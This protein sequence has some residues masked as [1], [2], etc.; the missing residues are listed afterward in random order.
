MKKVDLFDPDLTPEALNQALVFSNLND[1]LTPESAAMVD[2]GWV[3][4]G[5]APWIWG[6]DGSPDDLQKLVAMIF[7]AMLRD[8]RR[9]R[10][11]QQESGSQ[12]P[13]PALNI[14][15]EASLSQG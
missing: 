13:F 8:A 2:A 7:L 9:T 14:Q 4:A 5:N 15:I 11:L 3:E 10:Q 6:S 12:R 1:I